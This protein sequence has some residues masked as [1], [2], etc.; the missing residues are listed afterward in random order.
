MV[1]QRNLHAQVVTDEFYKTFKDEI[2][3]TYIER[4]RREIE[5]EIGWKGVCNWGNVLHL[6]ST[7]SL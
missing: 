5:R 3:P 7:I 4:E 2:M 1:P 6:L